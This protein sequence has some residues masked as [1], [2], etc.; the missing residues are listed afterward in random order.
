MVGEYW[1]KLPKCKESLFLKEKRKKG[2]E[3]LEKHYY[4][5]WNRDDTISFNV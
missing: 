2:P 1:T 3:I 5:W 4:I